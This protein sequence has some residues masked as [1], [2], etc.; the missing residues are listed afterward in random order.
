M[1]RLRHAA[2]SPFV[3]KVM[4]ALHET[5]L[6]DEVE[7]EDGATSP[8][9]PKPGNIEMNPTGKIPCLVTEEG[10]ALYDSRVI[11]R[12]IDARTGGGLYPEGEALWPVLVLEA[13]ADAMMDAAVLAVYERRLREGPQI[14]EAWIAAQQGKVARALDMLEARRLDDDFHMG[15]AAIACALGYLDF[16]FPD[17][18]WRAGRPRLAAW[19]RRMLRR[20]SLIDTAPA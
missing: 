12:W 6:I 19:A 5:G 2:A 1:M 16:R 14:S 15:H 9:D 17:W 11:T 18:D 20:P 3:R 8:L 7:L 10:L 4:V 13:T